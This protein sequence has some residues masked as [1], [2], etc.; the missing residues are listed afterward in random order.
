MLRGLYRKV[1]MNRDQADCLSRG[2]AVAIVSTGQQLS[3]VDKCDYC[4]CPHPC[5]PTC[6]LKTEREQRHVEYYD[7]ATS[8]SADTNSAQGREVAPDPW[9]QPLADQD[10]ISYYPPCNTSD[11]WQCKEKWRN[12]TEDV[13]FHRAD[14]AWSCQVSLAHDQA[15]Q[16]R[17]RESKR[18]E[19]GPTRASRYHWCPHCQR[20]FRHKPEDCWQFSKVP[21]QQNAR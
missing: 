4:A 20:S 17:A 21:S 7:M 16:Q 3:Q 5:E 14:S 6:P 13:W 19:S 10:A 2:E 9:Q 15:R 8:E 1:G 18:A 11:L 12:D